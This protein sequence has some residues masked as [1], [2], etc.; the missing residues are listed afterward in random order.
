MEE[1]IARWMRETR[2]EY[3]KA[4]THQNYFKMMQMNRLEL[5]LLDMR[6]RLSNL[7]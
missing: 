1:M 6:D 3:N 2:T 7:P 5:A 4:K